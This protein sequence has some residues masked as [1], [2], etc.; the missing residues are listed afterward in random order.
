MGTIKNFEDLKI[1][2]L[3]RELVMKK[4]FGN[5]WLFWNIYH[6]LQKDGDLSIIDWSILPMDSHLLK[7]LFVV[8]ELI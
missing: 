3:A 1:W 5:R 8:S 7:R 4:V 6:F 2:L